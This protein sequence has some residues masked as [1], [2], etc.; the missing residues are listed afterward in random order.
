[1]GT[2]HSVP[3][4]LPTPIAYAA[5]MLAPQPAPGRGDDEGMAWLVFDAGT[6]PYLFGIGAPADPL[7][8]AA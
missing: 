4:A 7:A 8:V 5:V 1:M 6:E 3:A 2:R